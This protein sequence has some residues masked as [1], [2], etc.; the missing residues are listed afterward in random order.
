MDQLAQEAGDGHANGIA[1]TTGNEGRLLGA[2]ELGGTKINAAVGYAGGRILARARIPT[3]EP[4]ATMAA[5]RAFFRDEAQARGPV[6]ALG[7]G[8]F[9]PVVINRKDAAYGRLLPNPKPGWSGFDLLAA[10]DGAADGPVSLTTDVGAAGVGEAAAGALSGVDCGV[11]LTI[12]TGIG[13]AI[14]VNGR[15]IP[16]LLHPEMGHFHLKMRADDPGRC[17]CPFHGSCAEG[18]IAGPAIMARYGT[19]LDAFAPDGPEMALVGDY[20]GQLL[21]AVVLAVS[22]QR[23]VFGGGV[24][25]AAGVHEAARKGMLAALN[26]YVGH[27]L[28]RPDFISPPSLGDDAGLTGGLVLAADALA[29]T[30]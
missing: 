11:Y 24:S 9:G 2:I 12:G 25:K 27:G 20:A 15:P 5:V 30:R 28:D 16:A 26:G 22:P 18:L 14:I 1:M 17:V 8:A 19:S 10:L 6:A 7:I 4:V 29:E 3:G 13:A 21:A 23:I